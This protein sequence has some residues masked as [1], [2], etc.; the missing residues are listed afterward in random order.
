MYVELFFKP[1]TDESLPK[2]ERNKT[3]LSLPFKGEWTVFWG[4]DTK[5]QNYHVDVEAQ[6]NAFDIIVTDE[7]G[8]SYRTNGEKNEDYYAF[9]KELIAPC[10]GEVVLVVDG[11]KD[12]QPGVLNPAY[13]PGNTVI[14][15]TANNEYL[16]FAH[17][18]QHSI[19]VKQGQKLKQGTLLGLCGNSGNSSEP[20]LHFHIQNV[21]DINVATGV[22]CYFDKL[23]VN[24]EV[25]TDYSPVKR[26]KVKIAGK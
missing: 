19:K 21:E 23:V 15:K 11:I 6:K 12:N 8:K 9:G 22:K 10:D 4:G 24:G 2:P 16:F 1:F 5:E 7:K 25:K 3:K 13:V 14:I 26:D 20:H 18:K 17:F